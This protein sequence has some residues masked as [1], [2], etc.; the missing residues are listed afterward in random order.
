MGARADIPLEVRALPR[1]PIWSHRVRRAGMSRREL[2]GLGAV[3][4]VAC[5][6]GP[7]LAAT[8]VIAA[9]GLVGTML[10]GAGA[11]AISSAVLAAVLAVR[12]HRTDRARSGSRP[13]T[14]GRTRR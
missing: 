7:L 13:V 6:A 11:L 14:L 8:G 5:C 9:L 10:Y 4:C 3:A 12:R 2:L 1:Q